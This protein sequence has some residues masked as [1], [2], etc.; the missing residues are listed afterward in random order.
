MLALELSGE[1]L[2]HLQS[3]C[4]VGVV[5]GRLELAVDAPGQL[6]REVV[7]DVAAL[8]QDA[9][10]HDGVLA[11]DALHARGEGLASVDDDEQSLLEAQV[12]GHQVGEEVA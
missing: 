12:P 8:V 6:G 5:E 11:E 7:S 4:G 9:T 1:A 3:P 10:L 2:G